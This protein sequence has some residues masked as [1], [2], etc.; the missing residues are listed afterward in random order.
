MA[1]HYL[2]DSEVQ[3]VVDGLIRLHAREKSVSALQQALNEA[4]A[5]AAI[6]GQVYANR[7]HTLLSGEPTRSVNTDTLDFVRTALAA[8]PELPTEPEARNLAAS[9][10]DQVKRQIAA[11]LVMDGDP[12]AAVAERLRIPRAVVRWASGNGTVARATALSGHLGE[13][14]D[15]VPRPSPDWSFQDDA[16]TACVSALREGPNRKIGL[17]IPTGGGKTRIAVRI[18]LAM[19]SDCPRDDSVVL[20]ITHRLHLKRLAIREIQRSLAE[21]TPDLPQGAVAIFEERIETCMISEVGQR[22]GVLGERVVLVVV[23]EAHHAAAP[24][25]RPIFEHVPLQGLF[26]TATPN[27][28]DLL[29]IGIDEIT[30]QISYREL[31]ARGVIVEP[32]IETLLATG[33]DWDD[34]A[35]FTDLADYLI[36][37]ADTDFVKTVVVLPRIDAVERLYQALVD[38]LKEGAGTI[39]DSDIVQWVHGSQSSTGVDP[40]TFLENFK[41]QE[42]GFLVTTQQLL[43]EGFDDAL[44]NAMVVAYPTSSLIQLMQA[45][46]RAMRNSPGKRAYL[47]QVADS[48]LQYHWTQQWLYQDISDSLRPQLAEKTYGSRDELRQGITA[49]LEAHRVAPEVGDAILHQLN[50]VDLGDG[51]SLLL[52]GLPF[53]GD[54]SSFA[55]TATWIAIA[56]TPS[57]RSRF[58]QLFNDFCA[59]EANVQ[60]PQDFLRNYVTPNT[61]P[62]AEWITHLDMLHAMS[63]ARKELTVE[64][65]PGSD[66]RRYDPALGSTWLTYVTFRYKPS[67]P[68]DLE[69]FLVDVVNR[70]ELSAAYIAQPSKWLL[71]VK[72]PL[73]LAGYLG[74]LLDEVQTPWV[75]EQRSA[76]A[77]GLRQVPA[78]DAFGEVARWRASLD[79]IPIAAPLVDNLHVLVSE[80]SFVERSLALQRNDV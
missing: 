20:W 7:L 60:D 79:F 41:A 45:A 61:D 2:S 34:Q 58:I 24:S 63:Y 25:Y 43:G 32:Q 74:F 54:Q 75:A 76:L 59:R 3:D 36:D 38:R 26:L 44:I 65:Y 22:L 5:T 71:A 77:G 29:P 31:F 13:E 37:R 1:R 19:L 52:S 48:P 62:G 18:A 57:T 72:I 56:V 27:R 9:L 16:H 69:A 6:D 33:D 68:D 40:Q 64:L 46:G 47:V 30:Y 14:A 35:R 67:L 8:V 4:A 11:E 70:D 15:R 17:V 51:V 78:S 21:G 39:V 23:D 53:Y 80:E 49:L 66:S 42:R 10:I 12:E 50:G 55:G 73:P 28:T